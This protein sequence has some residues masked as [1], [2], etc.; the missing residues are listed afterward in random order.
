MS[1]PVEA[2]GQMRLESATGRR[3]ELVAHGDKLVLNVPGWPELRDLMPRSMRARS[4]TL[5]TMDRALTT[6][7]LAFSLEFDRKPVFQLG[8]DIRPSFLAH[9]L[10]LAPARITFSFVRLIFQR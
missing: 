2:H 5:R 4:R 10:G 9:L 6:Y 8:R 3:V 1:L 7:G